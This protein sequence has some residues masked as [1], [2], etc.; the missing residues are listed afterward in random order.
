MNRM[1]LL[2]A[3]GLLLAMSPA[4]GSPGGPRSLLDLEQ[5]AD[6]IVIATASGT[7]QVGSAAGFSL[8]VARVVKGDPS[9]AGSVLAVSANALPVGG[10]ITAV[11]SGLWFLKHPSNA[12]ILL[13]VI[14]GSPAF[15]MTFFPEPVGPVLSPYAYGPAAPL[16]DRIASEICSAIESANGELPIQFYGLQ[17]G[18]LDQLNSPVVALH[19]QRMSASGS[20]QQQILGLNGLIRGGSGPALATAIQAAFVFGAYPLESGIL[21]QSVRDDFRAADA[22]SIAALGQSAVGSANPATFRQAAAHALAAIHTIQTL[23]YLSTLLNDMDADLRVEAIRGLGA[24]ANGLPVQTAARVPSLAYLQLPP[25]APFRTTDT[26]ANFALGS[27]AIQRDEAAYLSFWKQ[28][29]TEQ[30]TAL[31]F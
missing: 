19:Y 9:L 30:R 7:F 10:T 6:L 18:L 27:N 8:L 31:G 2:G 15:S 11:G 25:S 12:W 13:P 28:W 29:W 26:L 3:V 1:N 5:S 24:F 17:Y 22:P 23:P 14:Q 20:E 16:S 21:R 4:Y